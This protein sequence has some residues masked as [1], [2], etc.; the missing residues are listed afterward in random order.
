MSEYPDNEFPWNFYF[1]GIVMPKWGCCWSLADVFKSIEPDKH[2][3]HEIGHR[4]IYMVECRIDHVG[5]IESEDPSLFIYVVQEVLTNL[6]YDRPTVEEKLRV[7]SLAKHAAEIY[8]GLVEAAFQMREL[9]SQHDYAFWTTGYEA[10]R[11]RLVEA[12]RRSNLK[13]SDP[14]FQIPPHIQTRKSWLEFEWK[15]QV[16]KLHG[17][18]SGGGFSKELR[19]RLLNI[20]LPSTK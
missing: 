13:S 8:D 4:D 19:T 7:G 3:D 6:L 18:A 15:R 1:N 10:D 2:W 11:L 5:T 17:F 9:T 20:K 16:K 14:D 12:I